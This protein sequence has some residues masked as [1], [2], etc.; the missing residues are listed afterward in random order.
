MLLPV[1]G[2]LMPVLIPT[3]AFLLGA[4]LVW[5]Y[6]RQRRSVL[7]ERLRAREREAAQ[8]AGA[9]AEVGR[10]REER[11]VLQ[12]T[13]E[14]ERQAAAEKLR[15]LDEAQSRLSAAFKALSAEA[16]NNNNASF[17]HLAKATLETFQES[18]RGDLDRRQQ[19]IGELVLPLK[20]S[21]LKVDE[22]IR[23]METARAV[24]Y[25]SLSEHLK[26][27]AS[28]QGGLERETARLAG[29][30]RSTSTRGRWGEIQLQRV[31]EMAGMAAYCDFS[32]QA[33]VEGEEGRLR[34]DLVV[35]LPNQK[36]VVIDAKAPLDAYL[37]AMAATDEESRKAKLRHHARQIRS[38]L[39]RLAAKNY[40]A[41]FD[42]APE[43]VVLFLPG[44]S[45]FGAALEVD[46]SLIEHGVEQRVI[47]A[48]P[49]TL[50]ALLQAVAFGWRQAQVE[51]N[52]K[53]ISDLG[54]SLYER[55]RTFGGHLSNLGRNLGQSVEAYNEA[56]GSL[57][58]RVLPGARRFRE[59]GAAGGDEIRILDPIDKA[60]R[61]VDLGEAMADLV[62]PEVVQVL[63]GP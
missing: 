20:E 63:G 16:L 43:F 45:F 34:P 3:L 53:Q 13:I 22:K 10:L 7:E 28:A 42:P 23:E 62:E 17:V 55:L 18:A 59:L 19:A 37:D 60:T 51:E 9:T 36:N 26:G 52:A 25:S 39:T 24:A 57:E 50:I 31:V 46:A 6:A 4:V 11:A 41:Q 49:T 30:L 44:E 54:K 47:L 21:L 48:T 58:R 40:W 14:K 12:T 5:L 8:L 56:V 27:L 35:R 15:L 33:S 29:A 32:L 61:A 2:E 1:W 38:H